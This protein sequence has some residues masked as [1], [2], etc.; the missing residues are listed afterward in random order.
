M[1]E[2]EAAQCEPASPWFEQVPGLGPIQ[3]ETPQQEKVPFGFTPEGYA[4]DQ[5]A[6]KK[7]LRQRS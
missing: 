6:W 3:D 1:K 5:R 4:E 2:V 7:A